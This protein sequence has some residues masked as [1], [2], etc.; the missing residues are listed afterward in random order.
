MKSNGMCCKANATK[1]LFLLS[2]SQMIVQGGLHSA[3]RI[4]LT[5]S[6]FFSFEFLPALCGLSMRMPHHAQ[7]SEFHSLFLFFFLLLFLCRLSFCLADS[8]CFSFYANDRRRGCVACVQCVGAALHFK[9]KLCGIE[10]GSGTELF[11]FNFK[12]P[13]WKLSIMRIPQRP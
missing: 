6:L 3:S 2:F 1:W 9:K 7:N 10:R 4:S 12:R 5:C 8:A 13:C 11:K